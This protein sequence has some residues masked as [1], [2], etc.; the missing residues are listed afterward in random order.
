MQTGHNLSADAWALGCLMHELLVGK[1]PF[2]HAAEVVRMR[3]GRRSI[4]RAD[5][6]DSR[7]MAAVVEVQHKGIR[8]NPN[9]LLELDA[10]P[11]SVQM[12]SSLL[13]AVSASRYLIS[14]K[15]SSDIVKSTF[16]A[17]FDWEGLRDITMVA[18]YIPPLPHEMSAEEKERLKVE[19][20]AVAAAVALATNGPL[21]PSYLDSTVASIA[22]RTDRA[23]AKKEDKREEENVEIKHSY[24][25]DPDSP[26][27]GDQSIFADF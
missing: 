4:V 13:Q 6:A 21:K 19:A 7:I 2:D 15:P 18:P 14:T 25:F 8:L 11:G 3:G 5:D 17:K 1:T 26:F 22:S 10:V 23:K 20:D 9:A 24:L 12:I 27:V 16:F